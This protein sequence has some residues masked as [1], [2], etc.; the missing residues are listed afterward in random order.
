[1]FLSNNNFQDCLDTTLPWLVPPRG[2]ARDPERHVA[3]PGLDVVEVT[4]CDDQTAFAIQELLAWVDHTLRE[5]G[6]DHPYV[7]AKVHA[8]F[9]KGGGK[10]IPTLWV[11]YAQQV[12]DPTGPGYVR[13]RDLGLKSETATHTVKRGAWLR[14]GVDVAADGGDE[15]TIY[16]CVGDVIEHRHHSS[17]SENDNQVKVAQRILEEIEQAQRLADALGSTAPAR[18]KID[19]NGLGHDAVGMLKTW[20]ENGRHRADVVGVMVSESPGHDDPG[21]VMRL[22][23]PS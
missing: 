19:Q 10:A 8:K 15:F 14:L 23:R 21:A 2:H 20:A 6:E 17:G 4:A 7:I 13:L 3:Q 9:P 12:E 11:E 22:S 16:R 18:V 5:Y 1:V